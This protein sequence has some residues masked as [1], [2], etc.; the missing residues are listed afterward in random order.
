VTTPF[1]Q[2]IA[3]PISIALPA[4]VGAA[5]LAPLL[6]RV[7]D[8]ALNRQARQVTL[9]LRGSGPLGI[10]GL[11]HFVGWILEIQDLPATLR[12][13][14]HFIGDSGDHW[15]KRG[16]QALRACAEGAISISFVEG[17]A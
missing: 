11:Q 15:Q 8:D 2:P 10:A 16:L 5:D 6:A 1:P 12:Y 13:T 17:N 3:P 4:G 14:V 9:D 7:H